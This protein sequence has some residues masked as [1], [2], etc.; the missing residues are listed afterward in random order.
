MKI[1]VMKV[2]SRIAALATLCVALHA[3]AAQSPT[4]QIVGATNKFLSTLDDAQRKRVQFAFDDQQQRAR[5]SNL[6]IS[7]V[8][9]AGLSM[10]E[11]N[12]AQRSAA[13][14]VVA[15]VLS[16]KGFEK[17]QHIME[18][19]ELL[20]KDAPKP[21]FGKDLYFISILG[22]PSEKAPWMLQFGGH[23]LAL[24]ITIAGERGVLTPS[25][26]G[27]Q[28]ALYKV[29]DTTIRPL[30]EE[31]DRALALLNA[32]DEAQR[33][34]A[35]LTYRVADLGARTGT[36]RQD[37]S[38][39][40]TQGVGDERA[41]T[42]HAARPDRRVGHHRARQLGRAAHGGDQV[43][44]QRDMVRVE[45]RHDSRC[46]TEY[47]GVLP[48][49]GSEPRDRVCPAAAGWRSVDARTYD[50]PRSDERLR[51]QGDSK[52]SAARMLGCTLLLL[53][54]VPAGAHRLDEYLQATTIALEKGKVEA[55]LRLVPGVAVFPMVF[56]QI[57]GD[58]D[59][60]A[61]PAEERAYAHRVLDDLSLRIDDTPL[62]LRL[63]SS[64]FSPKVL[65]EDGRGEIRIKLEADVPAWP[66]GTGSFS[67]IGTSRAS[68]PISR[69]CWCRRIP[70][71]GFPRPSA[72]TMSRPSGSPTRT[73]APHRAR[74]RGAGRIWRLR[75]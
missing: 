70:T 11:L 66:H 36:G 17:V 34:Q 10:G 41:T 5:W 15:T 75:C 59:G 47:H 25:L 7:S 33:K 62:P 65:L 3:V 29:N 39:G 57:D 28:P 46:G 35:I 2:L 53:A 58:A 14:A 43:G 20:R 24:N 18:A 54:A 45:R 72:I 4:A 52:M 61:S 67:R 69:T 49:P 6:P 21:I 63:V 13:L 26:V 23:H 60:I 22:T 48:H 64:A 16:R 9:R 19:D 38:A 44:A 1:C 42:D 51:A 32:L 71:F 55:E 12:S 50:L 68:V 74:R 37:D 73:P 8:P 31:S 40:G 27:A 56:A 30:G